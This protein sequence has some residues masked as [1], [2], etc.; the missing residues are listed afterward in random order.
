MV[1]LKAGNGWQF[2]QTLQLVQ[3]IQLWLLQGML[4]VLL[5]LTL[6][7]DHKVEVQVQNATNSNTVGNKRHNI[8]VNY[9]GSLLPK[10][11]L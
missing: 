5:L 7:G 2:L 9:T 4:R 10:W 1:G 3:I 8:G 11:L 6:V